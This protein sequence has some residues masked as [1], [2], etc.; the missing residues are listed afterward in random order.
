MNKKYLLLVPALALSTITFAQKAKVNEATRNLDKARTAISEKKEAEGLLYMQKA[1]TAL[2][3]AT[4][5]EATKNDAKTWYLKAKAHF[6]GMDLENLRNK[7]T[8]DKGNEALIKALE[9]N[10]KLTNDPEYV[11]LAINAAFHNYNAAITSFNAEDYITSF[12]EFGNVITYV[13]NKPSSKFTDA[14]SAIDTMRTASQFYQGKSS[15]NMDEYAKAETILVELVGNKFLEQNNLYYEL[16]S[17]SEKTKNNENRLKY[18]NMGRKQYPEDENF[19]NFELNYYIETKQ[20][21]IIIEKLEAAKAKD[22]KNAQTPLYL[23]I[24]YSNL[25]AP[26]DGTIPA[27]VTEYEKKAEENYLLA[28]SIAGDNADINQSLGIHYYNSGV[29][30]NNKSRNLNKSK[31]AKDQAKASQ[32]I[33]VRNIYYNKALPVLEKATTL[34]EA[35]GINDQNIQLYGNTLEALGRIYAT[36][37][38]VKKAN[39]IREKINNLK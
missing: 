2:D 37:N 28:Q 22:P 35:A 12:N 34:Y 20:Y 11:N 31:D 8:F 36:Q 33:N 29:E 3:E 30:A 17:L 39:E 38:N 21:P 15:A 24:V 26:E 10:P 7:E 13:G 1:I 25:A 5:N 14:Y 4:V 27:N 32:M 16:I 23:G 19:V 18:I 9:L 6:Y